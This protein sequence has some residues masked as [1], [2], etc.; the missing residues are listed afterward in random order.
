LAT[1]CFSPF[2][3]LLAVRPVFSSPRATIVKRDA[4][5]K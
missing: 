2:H 4:W 3:Y 5:F 1:V